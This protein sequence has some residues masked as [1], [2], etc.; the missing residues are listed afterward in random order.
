MRLYIV[1]HICK[2]GLIEILRGNPI[3]QFE[4]KYTIIVLYV[5]L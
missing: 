3:N 5:N 2:G 4:N 1:I